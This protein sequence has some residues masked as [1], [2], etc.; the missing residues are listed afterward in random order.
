MVLWVDQRKGPPPYLLGFG[1][2]LSGPGHPTGEE[3]RTH[4]RPRIAQFLGREDR[5]IQK[6]LRL[7]DV[8]FEVDR[9]VAQEPQRKREG[10]SVLASFPGRHGPLQRVGRGDVLAQ[11]VVGLAHAR[12]DPRLA[13]R[14]AGF[15]P[16]HRQRPLVSIDGGA[17]LHAPACAIARNEER[18]DRA[19]R[20]RSVVGV[21]VER[22]GRGQLKVICGQRG[23]A[24]VKQALRDQLVQPLALPLGQ[25]AID[26]VL[27]GRMADAPSLQLAWLWVADEDLGVLQLL[28]LL[29]GCLRVDESQLVQVEGVTEDRRPTRKVA[30][31]RLHGIESRAH[32]RLDRRRHAPRSMS[33]RAERG[34]HQHAGGL[35]DEVRV[36]SCPLGDLDR[37]DVTDVSTAGVTR[38]LH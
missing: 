8:R 30:K 36:A 7:V 37:L 33:I 26:H 27:E 12:Q 32:D 24:A 19:I 23:M 35:D 21:Q 17:A 31:A 18:V 6:L 28:Q 10:E 4:D 2:P 13:R 25:A 3:Q 22:S 29:S 14:P 38:K 15:R 34:R 20:E 1:K 9:D 16:G 11:P 5:P